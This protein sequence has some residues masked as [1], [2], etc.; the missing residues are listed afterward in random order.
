MTTHRRL[1]AIMFYIYFALFKCHIPFEQESSVLSP[2]ELKNIDEIC[3]QMDILH[4]DYLYLKQYLDSQ[5]YTRLDTFTCLYLKD[6][7]IVIFN[8]KTVEKSG[9]LLSIF[10]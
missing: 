6:I 1:S 8:Y 4:F 7:R 2:E 9:T 3:K 10:Q 5:K